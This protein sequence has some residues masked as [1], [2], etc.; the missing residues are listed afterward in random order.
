MK[1]CPDRCHYNRPRDTVAP[2]ICMACGCSEPWPDSP[3]QAM[4]ATLPQ[5]LIQ[6]MAA[7]QLRPLAP[8]PTYFSGMYAYA[9]DPIISA[10][11]GPAASASSIEGSLAAAFAIA[12]DG[13][14]AVFVLTGSDITSPQDVQMVGRMWREMWAKAGRESPPLAVLGPDIT[15]TSLTAGGLRDLGLVPIQ[16]DASPVAAVE[17]RVVVTGY[18][19]PC[20]GHIMPIGTVCRVKDD[21]TFPARAVDPRDGYLWGIGFG[22]LHEFEEAEDPMFAEVAARATAAEES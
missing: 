12:D 3:V 7:E 1:R 18:R 10:R 9:Q 15:L 2:R 11:H 17:R 22:R 4:A 20:A 16:P 13:K 5:V 8:P 19:G 14:P 6:A 21:F